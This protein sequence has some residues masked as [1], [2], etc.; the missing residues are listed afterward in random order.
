LI[1][2][3]GGA[4]FIGSN[5]IRGLNAR[6]IEDIVVVDDL[7]DGR[8]FANLVG[9]R[10]ADYLDKDEFREAVRSRRL[11]V[12]SAVIHQGACAVTTEWDGRYMLDTNYRFSVELYEYCR[13]AHIQFI[14]ASSAA[15]YGASERFIEHD[16]ALEQPLNV[17]GYSKLLFDQYVR[18]RASDTTAQVVGLRYFNV[19][20]PGEAFKEEMA[21]VA[22]HF[23]RQL[24]E[25]GELRLFE[26]SHGYG[27]GEQRRD[28]VY[29]DDV[30][31]VN[32]WFLEHPDRSGIFNV[33][34]GRS[35]PFNELARA[36]IAWHDRGEIRYVPFPEGLLSR[37]QSFTEADISALRAVGYAGEFHAVADG[38]RAYLDRI[39]RLR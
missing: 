5:I 37:Y 22:F 11:P 13:A 33:G 18:R 12:P 31:D 29:V 21:S 1:I 23:D 16:P 28:F 26:G 15:V 2:V 35:T 36:V 30:V 6:G 32:L 8:K 19:Y 9:S 4:G 27:P 24:R 7:T 3:T 10:V 39:G 38:V 34:T 17:Y 25:C 20:G 14:Y